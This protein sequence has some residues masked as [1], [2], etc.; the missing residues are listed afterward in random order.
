M[1]KGD[2]WSEFMRNTEDLVFLTDI[3]RYVE[4]PEQRPQLLGNGLRIF[5]FPI[6]MEES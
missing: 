5:A 1:A 6:S 4:N 2:P 3:Q